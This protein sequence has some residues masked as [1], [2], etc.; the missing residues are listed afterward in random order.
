MFGRSGVSVVGAKA[1][2]LFKN[3]EYMWVWDLGSGGPPFFKKYSFAVAIGE[4]PSL[5]A[6]IERNGHTDR[7]A[8]KFLLGFCYFCD[9][10]VLRCLQEGVCVAFCRI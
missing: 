7:E 9:L 2:S 6:A 8:S 5:L 4:W 3:V 10:K 1:S